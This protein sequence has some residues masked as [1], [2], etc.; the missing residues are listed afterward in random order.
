MGLQDRF[1]V[2]KSFY[3]VQKL[4]EDFGD[5]GNGNHP[6][7]DLRSSLL[8]LRSYVLSSLLELRSCVLGSVLH[9]RSCILNLLGHLE[10]RKRGLK[11]GNSSGK[12]DRFG[13]IGGWGSIGSAHGHISTVEERSTESFIILTKNRTSAQ[14]F[15]W[16][17]TSAWDACFS[18]TSK[19]VGSYEA[20]G[21]LIF[22]TCENTFT[23]AYPL[24]FG[25]GVSDQKTGYKV[26]HFVW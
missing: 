15:S 12:G 3:L 9:S 7:L 25:A 8:E 19:R 4:V 2:F 26:H 10:L 21:L 11:L 18:A 17:A 22:T 24:G 13:D 20:T 5:L 16:A 6:F 14:T 1:A 23:S